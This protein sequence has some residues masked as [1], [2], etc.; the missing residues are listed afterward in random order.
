MSPDQCQRRAAGY[1]ISMSDTAVLVV[2]MMNSYQHSDAEV[3]I[4]NVAKADLVRRAR[5]S[6]DV[7]VVYVNDQGPPQRVL[8]DGAG[9]SARSSRCRRAGNQARGLPSEVICS[10]EWPRDP[11]T[12]E[13]NGPGLSPV[14]R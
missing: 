5:E 2:D 6:D 10:D 4:P 13:T 11:A 14:S 9:V 1:H 3:L 12:H 7:D 8:L